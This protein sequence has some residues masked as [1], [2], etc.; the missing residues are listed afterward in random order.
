MSTSTST[1]YCYEQEA[2]ASACSMG[3]TP[4]TAQVNGMSDT[5]CVPPGCPQPVM[6]LQ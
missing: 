3:T 2:T 4:T 6:W 1:N 5:L